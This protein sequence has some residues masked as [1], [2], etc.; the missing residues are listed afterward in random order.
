MPTLPISAA[1]PG[2]LQPFGAYQQDQ[3]PGFYC[4]VSDVL[5]ES[6]G[7]DWATVYSVVQAQ[8]ALLD[9]VPASLPDFIK[10]QMIPKAEA[11]FDS[12]A[13]KSLKPTSFS[14]AFDGDDTRVLYISPT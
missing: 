11:L 12:Y 1:V 6:M 2:T 4:D 13:K 8:A 9:I 5:T 10:N 3:L 14:R 7:L